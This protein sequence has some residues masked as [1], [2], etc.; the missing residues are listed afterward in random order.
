MKILISGFEAFGS[1][2]QNPSEQLVNALLKKQF[3]FELV[4]TILPVSFEDAFSKLELLILKYQ[5]NYAISFGVARKRSCITPE[6]IAINYRTSSIADNDGYQP[7]GEEVISNSADGLFTSL[8]IEQMVKASQ[9]VGVNAEVSNTAGTY[10]CND[11]MYKLMHMSQE[12]NFK[13]GFIHIPPTTSIDPSTQNVDLESLV[14][15]ASAMLK[16]LFLNS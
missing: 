6:R 3:N 2:K 9:S 15:G 16:A 1:F 5:P 7:E 10:V 12:H 13:A 4:G 11:V 8:P 14:L